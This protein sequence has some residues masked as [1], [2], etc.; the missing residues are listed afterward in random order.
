MIELKVDNFISLKEISLEQVEPI[1]NTINNERNYLREWLPFVDE[2]IEIAYTKTF[3]ENV[4]SSNS[5]DII[6]TIYFD[7]NFVGLVGLKD[8]DLGNRKSE[9]G[10]WLSEAYQHKGIITNSCQTLIKYAFNELDLNRIQVKVATEN[11]K[12]QRVIERLGFNKE[13]IEREGELHKRG[14]L[15][16]I[17]YSLLKREV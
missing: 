6:F 12:S 8:V 10:Y 17:V 16:L 2:T 4:T 3:V 9:L 7:S 11:F 5:N 15:D 14:F 13:G 1:F